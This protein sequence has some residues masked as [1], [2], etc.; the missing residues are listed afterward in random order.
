MVNNGY[1]SSVVLWG[2]V[3]GYLGT[4]RYGFVLYL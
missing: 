1:G 2:Y 3:Y 4:V